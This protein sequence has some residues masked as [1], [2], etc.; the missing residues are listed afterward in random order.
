MVQGQG[1]GVKDAGQ[2]LTSVTDTVIL[3]ENDP[4]DVC[5][6]QYDISGLKTVIKWFIVFCIS[7]NNA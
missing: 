6:S 4:T 7:L 3:S 5:L 1:L 2:G